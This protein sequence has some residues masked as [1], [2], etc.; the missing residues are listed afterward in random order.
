MTITAKHFIAV[1]VV[2]LH[3]IAPVCLDLAGAFKA[4]QRMAAIDAPAS[5]PPF[6]L[7]AKRAGLI[8]AL[9]IPCR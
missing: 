3:P 9:G 2:A 8:Y 4:H 7:A 6:N 1:F 5:K